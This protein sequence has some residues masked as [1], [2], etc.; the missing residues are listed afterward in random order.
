MRPTSHTGDEL[1]DGFVWVK[2]GGVSDGTSDSAALDFVSPCGL[3]DSAR[4]MPA[5]GEWSQDYFE[6]LLRNARPSIEI[7]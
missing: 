7:G 6:M 2:N 5:R 4:P 3:E 1:A